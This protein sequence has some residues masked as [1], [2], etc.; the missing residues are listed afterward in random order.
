MKKLMMYLTAI[1]I[2]LSFNACSNDN[3]DNTND[4]PDPIIGKWRFSQ[5]I[6]T[7]DDETIDDL[8]TECDKKSTIEFLE[9]GTYQ[10]SV[11]EFNEDESSCVAQDIINGTWEN[12]DT[13]VYNF[14]D[15]EIPELT[16]SLEA[17]V[18]FQSNKLV[19]EFSGT[20]NIDEEEFDISAKMI[21][22]DNDDYVPDNIIGKWQLD[23]EIEDG[24]EQELT[25]CAKTMTIQFFEDGIYE[26]KDFHN[27][28][29]ECVAN[30]VKKGTWKNLQNNMYELTDIEVPE[31]K[32]TFQNNTTKMTVEFSVTIEDE[33][34]TEKL[35]FQKVSS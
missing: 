24:V 27:E 14:T 32:I 13:H 25:D 11:F 31:V 19:L 1:F 15:F 33:T 16:L 23:Q 5:L 29:L 30:E 7:V 28:D 6:I 4:N 18:T 2:A 3:D 20:I 35:I 21:F 12:Y 22:I 34:H 8:L 9:N 17:K 26:E 10:L